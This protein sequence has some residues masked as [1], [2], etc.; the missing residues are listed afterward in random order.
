VPGDYV[1]ISVVDTGKGMPIDVMERVFEPFFTTKPT[2]QGTGLGL[3][4]VYGFVRQ[5]GG[6]VRLKSAPGAAPACA[7]SCRSGRGRRRP[8]TPMPLHSRTQPNPARPCCWWTTN[9]P[10][11]RQ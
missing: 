5:S 4:Q 11:V 6:V 9:S 8:K 3:S 10:H 7:S 1:E 2:G